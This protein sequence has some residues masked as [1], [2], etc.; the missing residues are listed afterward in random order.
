MSLIPSFSVSNLVGVFVIVSLIPNFSN[1][2]LT[3]VF[4]TVSLK[5]SFSE[6]LLDRKSTRL[7][8]SH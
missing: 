4:A 2:D 3:G 8:S 5:P 7:N 1:S 6:S